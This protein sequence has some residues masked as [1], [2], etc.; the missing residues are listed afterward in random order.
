MHFNSRFALFLVCTAAFFASSEELQNNLVKPGTTAPTFSLPNVDGTRT[1]LRNYAGDTLNMPHINKVHQTVILSF[2]ATYCKPCVKEMPQLIA[3]MKKHASDP[4]KFFPVSIDKEGALIV[5]PFL[6]EKA[7]EVES[8]L[9]PY[10]RTAER[11][12]VKSLPALFVIDPQGVVRYA[13]SG[14]DEGTDLQAKLESV[15][16][17]IKAGATAKAGQ[18]ENLGQTVEAPVAA[19]ALAKIGA[20]DRWKAVARVECGDNM[21]RVASDVGVSREDIKQW[22][23]EL[24]KAATLIWADSSQK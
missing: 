13:S 18:V 22:Y 20:R 1:V 16:G 4:I 2:W 6:A 7:W 15:L 21:E 17:E 5:K 8:L 10:A 14:F 9:D 12:G 3:F 11:Y 23:D 24:K 19:P